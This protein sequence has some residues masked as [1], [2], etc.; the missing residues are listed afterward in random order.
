MHVKHIGSVRASDEQILVV[1]RERLLP[2]SL[3]G[4]T[5]DG[6]AA[7][8]HRVRVYATFRGRGEVEQDP[9]MKQIIPY[10]IVRHE[11][12]LFLFQRSATGG[13]VRLHRKYSI[14]LG[15]HINLADVQEA[16][17]F[18]DA[19]LRREL[20]EELVIEGGWRARLVGVLNDDTNAVGRVHF[21]LVHVIEVD[22]P[23]I[24]VRESATLSGRLTVLADV[25]RLYDRMET[26]S[27][28]ILD[29]AD[30]AKI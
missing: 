28:L 10:L 4:F 8:L 2:E 3:H 7:Y 29:A 12:R 23:R 5:T 14:G 17:D 19:G 6:A 22:S 25:R 9:S 30:P 15:G 20:D 1:P 26:W 27:Q 16:A 13:E 11:G 24:A 21:G 18:V